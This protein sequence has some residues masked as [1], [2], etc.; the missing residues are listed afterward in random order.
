MKALA[1]FYV[2]WPRIDLDIENKVKTLSYFV[3]RLQEEVLYECLGGGVPLGP[4]TLAYTR[5]CSAA[6][7]F[8]CLM[9]VA[10][11]PILKLQSCSKSSI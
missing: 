11:E 4:G 2:W 9:H 10:S 8:N 1:M 3:N 7:L 6:T 5:L